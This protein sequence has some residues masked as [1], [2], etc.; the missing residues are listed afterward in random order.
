MDKIALH[1]QD[2]TQAEALRIAYE[3]Q[4]KLG[5]GFS[6]ADVGKEAAKIIKAMYKEM[7]E[8]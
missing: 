4:V 1:D 8:P 5:W 6:M 2:R 7:A 3:R